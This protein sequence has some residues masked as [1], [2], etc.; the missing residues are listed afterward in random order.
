MHE[1]GKAVRAINPIDKN[2]LKILCSILFGQNFIIL[3]DI[4][5]NCCL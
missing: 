3:I 5:E 1:K 2:K 4:M